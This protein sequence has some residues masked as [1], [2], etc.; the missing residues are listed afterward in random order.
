MI[1]K[2]NFIH[3]LWYLQVLMSLLSKQVCAHVQF[4]NLTVKL[5]WYLVQCTEPLV[6]YI[7]AIGDHTGKHY[8]LAVTFFEESVFLGLFLTQLLSRHLENHFLEKYTRKD[9]LKNSPNKW[10]IFTCTVSQAR[11][12]TVVPRRRGH[13]LGFWPRRLCT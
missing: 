8:P 3:N 10:V 13:L 2:M 9:L 5:V 4:F 7:Q 12:L 1:L 6:C 11:T